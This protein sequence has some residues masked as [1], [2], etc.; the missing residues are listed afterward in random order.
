MIVSLSKDRDRFVSILPVEAD[1]RCLPSESKILFVLCSDCFLCGIFNLTGILGVVAE[2]GEV[3]DDERLLPRCRIY[4]NKSSGGSDTL[5]RNFVKKFGRSF[6][7]TSAS[8]SISSTV[9][10]FIAPLA[11]LVTILSVGIETLFFFVCIVWSLC[12]GN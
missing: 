7:H 4:K 1:E 9:F 2:V 6:M 10:G 8:F 12:I 5:N 3:K 11:A